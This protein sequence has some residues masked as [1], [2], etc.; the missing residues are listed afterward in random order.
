MKVRILGSQ[1]LN[2]FLMAAIF[3]TLSLMVNTSS[4]FAF[5][6]LHMGNVDRDVVLDH[7]DRDVVPDVVLAHV[8][9]DVVPDVVHALVM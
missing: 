1:Y 2:I 8:D 9:R 7:V 4:V 5:H 6:G 3:M